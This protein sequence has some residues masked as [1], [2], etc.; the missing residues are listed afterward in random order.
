MLIGYRKGSSELFFFI[1]HLIDNA[2]G[3]MLLEEDLS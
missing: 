1:S 3:K 2:T